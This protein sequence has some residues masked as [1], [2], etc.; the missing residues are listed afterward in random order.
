L[1]DISKALGEN[2]CL[3]HGRSPAA[4]ARLAGVYHWEAGAPGFLSEWLQ[5]ATKERSF[6]VDSASGVVR[7]YVHLDDVVAALVRLGE[8]AA[9][10]LYNVASGEN[11]SNEDIMATLNN[12]GWAISMARFSER[13]RLP[14]CDIAPL[15]KLGIAPRRARDVINEWARGVSGSS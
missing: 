1:Y 6:T 4:V 12:N 14:I 11:V 9:T 15:T 7:D 13:E 5:R 3:C 8:T 2:L 10:G